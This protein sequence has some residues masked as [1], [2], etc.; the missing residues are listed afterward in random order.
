MTFKDVDD[1]LT[2]PVELMAVEARPD[3]PPRPP[4]PPPPPTSAP[5]ADPTAGRSS[6][7][8]GP[9]RPDA[10]WLTARD[11]GSD[12]AVRDAGDGG[13]AHDAAAEDAGEGDGG[14]SDSG[15]IAQ[16]AGVRDG[17]A[18]KVGFAGLVTAGPT[19]VRLLLNVALIR[20]HPVGAKMGPL[21]NGIP[22]WADF[23]KGTQTLVDPV[24]DTDWILIYGPSLI[25]TERDAIF[26]RYGLPDAIVDRAIAEATKKYAKGGPYDAGVPGVAASLGHADQAERVFLRAQPQEA[27]VVPPAKAHDFALLLRHRSVDPG[28]RPGEAVRLIVRDPHRQVAVPGL[29]FPDAMTEL[30]LWVVPRADGGAEVFADGECKGEAEAAD[31]AERTREFL[32]N[33]NTPGTRILTRGLLNHVDIQVVGNVVKTHLS[34]SREQIETVLHLVAANMGVQ[35]PAPGAAPPGPVAPAGGAPRPPPVPAGGARP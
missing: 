2:V 11:A 5:V 9:E 6:R 13:E 3:P 18:P 15:A 23:M 31:A 8:A 16:G 30:R 10:S 7:D 25:H 29:K 27:A 17:G 1:E 32:K 24:R 20:Q 12:A 35:L 4:E 34:A 26:I 21:L 22:Q 14:A 28:L 19:N 33:V